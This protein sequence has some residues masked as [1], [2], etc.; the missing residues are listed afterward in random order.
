MGEEKERVLYEDVEV[1]VSDDKMK[2]FIKF[3]RTDEGVE[4]VDVP[5]IRRKINGF[6]VFFGIEDSLL[7]KAVKH[8]EF[9]NK[10][11]VAEGKPFEKGEDAKLIFHFERDKSLAPKLLQ[12]GTADFH[13]LELIDNVVKG[14]ELVTMIPAVEGT[15]GMNVLGNTIKPPKPKEK[16]MPRGKNVI[17]TENGE[18]LVAGIDGQVV[19]EDGRVHV[20][21]THE[22]NGDVDHSTG[23]IEFLGN[24]IVRGN[25]KTG[26][27]I[28]SGGNVEVYGIVEGAEITAEGDIIL[29]KGMQ[30]GKKGILKAGGKVLA[31]Y[32]ENAKVIAED[33]VVSE[34][35]MHSDVKSHSEIDVLGNKGLI[36]GGTFEARK[37]IMAKRIGSPLATETKL[38]VGFDHKLTDRFN[39]IKKELNIY[40]E[41]IQKID[42]GLNVFKNIQKKAGLS[43]KK[44]AILLKLVDK[45]KQYSEKYEDL[46]YELE[47][48]KEK[49]NEKID[50]KIHVSDKV[51]PGTQITIGKTFMHVMDKRDYATFYREGADIKVVPYQK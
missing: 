43:E 26:F 19:H 33:E 42:E 32:I 24:V 46:E 6:G 14:Q 47:N 10:H 8:K 11:L 21:K 23:N 20:L 37:T 50:A 12:D 35:I 41:E 15:P 18:K 30:G 31:K 40:E 9:N 38:I 44:Q 51:F 1:S 45:R 34:A 36:A 3:I 39:E 4:E 29:D 16:K 28:N 7:E 27:K 25:V 2:A 17:R 22:I 49:L 5:H 13:N 48:I